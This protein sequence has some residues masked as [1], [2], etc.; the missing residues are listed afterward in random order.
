[1]DL[2]DTV[3]VRPIHSQVSTCPLLLGVLEGST[4]LHVVSSVNTFPKRDVEMSK[5]PLRKSIHLVTRAIIIIYW[6]STY[7]IN[8]NNYSQMIRFVQQSTHTLTTQISSLMI[9]SYNTT[10]TQDNLEKRQLELLTLESW[11][12]LMHEN[13]GFCFMEKISSIWTY[14]EMEDVSSLLTASVFITSRCLYRIGN[15]SSL[16]VDGI[17]IGYLDI[18][19][20]LEK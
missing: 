2:V 3:G 12:F 16:V 1:M 5:R 11:I 6:S 8:T 4:H 15:H 20:V 14:Y 13:P 19:E 10:T 17:V 9:I 18:N 7:I